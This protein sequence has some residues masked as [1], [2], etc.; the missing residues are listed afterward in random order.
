MR[1]SPRGKRLEKAREALHSREDLEQGDE[2]PFGQHAQERRAVL[3]LEGRR[4]HVERPIF[5]KMHVGILSRE[6][7]LVG[8]VILLIQLRGQDAERRWPIRHCREVRP[9]EIGITLRLP[10]GL[11]NEVIV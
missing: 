3:R 10:D 9:L 8:L 1:D 4:A 2:A 5:A 11:R 7:V 6:D